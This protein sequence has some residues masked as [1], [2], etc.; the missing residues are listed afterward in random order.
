MSNQVTIYRYLFFRY[1]CVNKY[2]ISIACDICKNPFK[3]GQNMTETVPSCY[4]QKYNRKWNGKSKYHYIIDKT[5]K[6]KV[7][8]WY[9]TLFN[10]FTAVKDH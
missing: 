8:N 1:S 10:L 4:Y 6:T 9:P 7:I 3:T 5:N 2:Y